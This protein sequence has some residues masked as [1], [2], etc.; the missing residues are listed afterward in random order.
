MKINHSFNPK[1]TALW[2]CLQEKY[3]ESIFRLDGESESQLDSVTFS[4]NFF[5][6]KTTADVSVDPNAN[7]NGNSSIVYAMES[8]KPSKRLQSLYMLWERI[9]LQYGINLANEIVELQIS[10]DIYINDLHGIASGFPYCFNYSTYDV[11]TKGL[12]MVEDIRPPKYLTSFKS[13]LEQFVAIAS[14]STLGATGLADMLVVMSYYVKNMVINLR[15]DYFNFKAEEDVWAYV[16]ANL[17]SFIYTVNQPYRSGVQ[18]PF[19]NISIY[20]RNFL[21]KLAEDYIFPDGSTIDIEIVEKLQELFID[22]MNMEMGRKPLTFPVTSACFSVDKGVIKDENFLDM[23]ARKN[24]KYGFMNIYMGSESTLSSCCRLRSEGN[25]EYF[26]SFGSGSSKIGSLG[27]CTIGL[28]RIAFKHI[29]DE[30]GFK[31]RLK[32]LTKIC[33]IVNNAKRFI[34]R[35]RIASGNLP[36]YTLG[37]M[38][39]SKQYSTTGVNGFNEA[40]EIMGYDITHQDGIDF[41][42]KIMQCINETND[43]YQ[44]VFRAPHNCEQIPGE[45]VS[46]K[47]AEKDQILGYN[48][49]KDGYAIY[50]M[51]SNQ[52]IPLINKADMLDRIRIQGIFDSKFSGGSILHLNVDTEIDSVEDMKDLIRANAKQG[53]IYFAINYVINKCIQGHVSVGKDKLCNVCGGQ[54]KD[55]FTRV[56]GFLTNTKNWNKV[57]RRIDYPNRTFYKGV[58][59]PQIIGVDLAK[60]GTSDYTA[61]TD[62]VSGEVT[63]SCHPNGLVATIN[64]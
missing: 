45:T 21:N 56:V 36:L 29:N 13:Q 26:N 53:V 51:Y 5:G 46:V 50:E 52:F 6:T 23:I 12:S 19:T 64:K 57:R 41:G 44:E 11:M 63:V 58:R 49:D 28:P 59:H 3:P 8:D 25:N 35:E 20:D 16:K 27:V 31:A 61:I 47:L 7:I 15:D 43:Y 33:A 60:E 42:L 37:F 1:F 2:E 48:V 40:I 9:K 30:L 14:N 4:E 22:C 18:S 24:L 62:P 32:Y 17:I 38:E 39:L 10:G 34:V 54:I 55:S